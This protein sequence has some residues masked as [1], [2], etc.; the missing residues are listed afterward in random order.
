MVDDLSVLDD[1]EG[2]DNGAEGG[3]GTGFHV[4]GGGDG[5]VDLIKKTA[6]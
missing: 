4:T 5:S 2:S 3:E 6:G 1:S